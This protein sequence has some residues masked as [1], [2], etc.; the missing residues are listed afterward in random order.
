LSGCLRLAPSKIRCRSAGCISRLA[1]AGRRSFLR[2][3]GQTPPRIV[4]ARQVR[5]VGSPLAP[6]LEE[7]RHAGR[8]ALI[9][10]RS[11]PIGMHG[12]ALGPLSPPTMTQLI[13]G[14]MRPR[15][16]TPRSIGPTP[17][18]AACSA[19]LRPSGDRPAS[20]AG[21]GAGRRAFRQDFEG[22]RRVG[23]DGAI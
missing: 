10:Q 11:R 12:R 23:Q 20:L 19:A 9:A 5:V 3:Q 17:E 18:A 4:V 21:E 7:E 22:L 8:L 15:R 6:L 14:C 16:I 2:P 1:A 13:R